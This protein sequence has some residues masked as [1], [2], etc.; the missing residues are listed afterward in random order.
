MPVVLSPARFRAG[1][2]ALPLED[3][4]ELFREV[5][6]ITLPIKRVVHSERQTIIFYVPT[7]RRVNL[8]SWEPAPLRIVARS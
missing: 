1:G 6:A 7:E 8:K 3:F 4:L 5:A 2:F